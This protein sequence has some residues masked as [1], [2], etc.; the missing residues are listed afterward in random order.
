VTTARDSTLAPAFGVF[1]PQVR[2]EFATIEKRV[3]AAEEAGFHSVWFMDHLA[4]PAAP[5]LDC[6]EAWT[7]AS[8]IAARTSAIRLGHLVLCD[9]FRPPALLAQMA[10]TL[11]VISGGRLE[12]GIGWGSVAGELR[13]FGFGDEPPARRSARLA[14]TLEI[15]ELLFSGERVSYAGRFTRLEEAIARPRPVAGRVPIHIGGAGPTLTLPLVARF[16]DWWNCPS[17]AVARLADLRPLAGDRVRV[18]VQHPVALA[19][20]TADRARTIEQAQ[21]RFGGWGGLIAGTPDEV[22]D[23]L[24]RE[25]EAG[26]E[27]FVLQFS[28]FGTPETL[29]LFADEVAPAVAARA[30][31]PG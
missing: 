13:S 7:V 31:R 28:D 26:A 12:L 4:P 21:R 11:D 9:P 19:P 8:A 22:A 17:Y 5:E 1:L 23:A 27:L 16:A 6:L 15:L 30:G 25:V 24:A 10:A 14:E 2:M 18:S 3:L 20:S 29:Q